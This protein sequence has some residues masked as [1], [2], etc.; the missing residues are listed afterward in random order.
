MLVTELNAPALHA[1]PYA[2]FATRLRELRLGSGQSY[3]V[4]SRNTGYSQS[5]LAAATAGN[6]LPSEDVMLAFVQSC[7]GDVGEWRAR[8]KQARHEALGQRE[9]PASA[10]PAPE[11]PEP[12]D[13]ALVTTP[14][15][16]TTTLNRLWTAS[17][18]PSIRRLQASSG[19]A[20]RRTTIHDVLTG[21]RVKPE[22][23]TVWELVRVLHGTARSPDKAAWQAAWKRARAWADAES[24]RF[25][26]LTP[27]HSC[28]HVTL[29]VHPGLDEASP[30]PPYIE[31]DID[32][33][34]RAAVSAAGEKGGFILVVGDEGAGKTRLAY[35]ALRAEVP[36]FG[37][38]PPAGEEDFSRPL[39][40][41][42][43]VW[44]DN[45]DQYLNWAALTPLTI[46]MMQNAADPVI[47]IGTMC[48]RRYNGSVVLPDS[49]PQEDQQRRQE[50]LNQA[51]VFFL[52]VQLSA[53]ELDRAKAKRA[54]PQIAV[55]LDAAD[56]ELFRTLASGPHLARRWASADR[57]ARAVITA[58]A[59]A[60]RVGIAGPLQRHLL[61]DAAVC[62]LSPRY[63]EQAGHGWFEDALAYATAPVPGGL[64]PLI[65]DSPGAGR[66]GTRAYRA[67]GY[68]LWLRES[69]EHQELAATAE[70]TEDLTALE[71]TGPAY[72]AFEEDLARYAVDVLSR[73]P[74]IGQ[75]TG[76]H[77][78]PE[79]H[80]ALKLAMETVDEVRPRFRD[81]LAS[82][83]WKPGDRDSLAAW[84]ME[85]CRE[86]LPADSGQSPDAG[87][88]PEGQRDI[89]TSQPHSSAGSAVPRIIL[90]THLRREREAA[91]ITRE[92]A[93]DEIGILESGL[94]YIELGR[95]SVRVD[96]V[97]KLLTLYRTDAR[98][99]EKL[100]ALAEQADRPG[101]WHRYHDIVPDWFQAYVGMEKIARSIRLYEQQLIPGLLQTEEYASAVASLC[102]FSPWDARRHAKFR[103]E[104][105]VRLRDQELH[106]WAVLDEAVLYR[107]IAG[108]DVQVRQL[109]RLR[110][111]L[112]TQPNLTIQIIPCGASAYPV[113]A[114]FSILRFTEPYLSDVVYVENLTSA[115]YIDSQPETDHYL[116]V[117]ERLTGVASDPRQTARILERVIR[118]INST[119]DRRG[120]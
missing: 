102:D 114:G 26:S 76:R 119:R 47:V 110:E 115:L 103:E 63:R 52:P 3:R 32:D 86:A 88:E 6:R 20:L 62:Y 106:L 48:A 81:G 23:N 80:G 67:A 49:A 42:T 24:R 9:D 11:P 90:G 14:A 29:G 2:D 91:L 104:R 109:R 57:Y 43:V 46:Q 44:L 92:K 107:A 84:F 60:R 85:M 82:G 83:S 38:F 55:A 56:S 94:G 30:Q 58:A 7:G 89:G 8:W 113:T 39:P 34:V 66:P 37:L 116:V 108:V 19:G 21:V 27:V 51:S 98:Q 105:Q 78:Y 31:R 95:S 99:K 40:P 5:T 10:T 100:L 70:L 69:K 25:P 72:L 53:A 61:R 74:S 50:V 18:R 12:S 75:Y 59:D 93:A 77:R 117:L 96:D 112:D 71:F 13:L 65:P 73:M 17:G 41:R 36:G 15:D 120:L 54:D 111:Q 118:D 22:W 101:W 45:I 87:L 97:L 35:E 4:L 68:L 1:S 28:D 33:D 64:A 79:H 16:L